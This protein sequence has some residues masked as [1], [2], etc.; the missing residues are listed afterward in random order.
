MSAPDRGSLPELFEQARAASDDERLRLLAVV[1]ASDERLAAE[2]EG[3]I[4]AA[5]REGTVLDRPLWAAAGTDPGEASADKLG[6][7]RLVR[8]IGR[9]GMGRVFLAEQEGDGFTR[10]VALKLLDTP[11]PGEQGVRRFHV[12]RRILASLEHPGIAHFYDGGRFAG[13][14][15]FMALEYVEGDDLVAFARRRAL[16]VEARVRLFLGVV[17]AVQ[18][19]H[20]RL[21]VH[22]DL[23]PANIIVGADGRTR[24]LD[25]G[26]S[27]LLDPDDGDGDGGGGDGGDGG[28]DTAVTR[29]ELRAM[30]PAYASPE[31]MRGERVTVA[32]DVYSLGVVL[33]E[34]LA[35]RRPFRGDSPR[36]LEQAVLEEDP[37]PPSAAAAAARTVPRDLDAIVL[38]ALRKP[39]NERYASAEALG[40]DL[41][42]F[43]SGRPVRARRGGRRYRLGKFVRRHRLVLTA[44]TVG[45]LA[46]GT[47]LGLALWQRA[48]AVTARQRAERR[49]ADVKGL[50]RSMLYEIHDGVASVPDTGPVR[51]LIAER[52]LEYLER[53]RSEAGD[54]PALLADLADGYERVGVLFAGRA[55]FQELAGDPERGEDAFAQAVAIRRRLLAAEP[56]NVARRLALALT[57][58]DY[59][60]TSSDTARARELVREAVALQR[61]LV[62]AAPDRADLAYHHAR[63]LVAS[64]RIE[65]AY[66]PGRPVD[67]DVGLDEAAAA[68]AALLHRP[69][70]AAPED[71]LFAE[72]T[73][74][75]AYSLYGEQRD[76]EAMRLAE[77]AIAY[78]EPKLRAGRAI[79]IEWALQDAY[80]TL[81]FCRMR[82]GRAREG[83]EAHDREMA[84]RRVQLADRER[85]MG[86]VINFFQALRDEAVLAAAIPDLARAEH[87]LDEAEQFLAT[88]GW[89]DGY[90]RSARAEIEVSRSDLYLAVAA[91]ATSP[92]ERDRLRRLAAEATERSLAISG[93]SDPAKR[94]FNPH[95]AAAPAA[96]TATHAPAPA[97]SH[98]D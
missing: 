74:F 32:S 55:G 27:K 87:A 66:E 83:L 26:I 62:D 3:M 75:M 70:F 37:E 67:T 98:G 43:L 39:A 82:S 9:G 14:G 95:G 24:L 86:V 58:E 97:H 15:W 16:S 6:P 48:E 60:R 72:D 5:A 23:K 10:R 84:I 19:A 51:A 57:L 45:V 76:D 52:A 79:G 93:Q 96:A 33:Y 71:A 17:E 92:V 30:T 31:Q 90:Q 59:G 2:L 34:L 13:G 35:D 80:R 54:D 18:Y 64:L 53:L 85:S 47:G 42:R 65:N 46:L 49:F 73:A 44:A 41:Q 4:A 61:A 25:F 1:R 22:R 69:G 21:V 56:D 63:V 50:A 29:T 38:K 36:A 78:G 11:D 28:G 91:T 8:E 20:A 77:W 81:A 68:W 88:T 40:D 89:K 12:E 7:Y 94:D